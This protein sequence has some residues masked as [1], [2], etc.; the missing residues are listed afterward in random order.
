MNSFKLGFASLLLASATVSL[1]TAGTPNILVSPKA[2][3]A[4]PTVTASVSNN[5][6]LVREIPT[7][8]SPKANALTADLRR[9]TD[10]TMDCCSA[11]L[12]GASNLSPRAAASLTG[13]NSASPVGVKCSMGPQATATTGCCAPA[14]GRKP[15]CCG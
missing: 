5:R 4:R 13:G 3:Q 9:T 15:T 2:A 8:G 10:A 6:D 1:T 12:A 14:P 7:L 11:V